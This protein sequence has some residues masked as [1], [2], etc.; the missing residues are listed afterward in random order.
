MQT[1][2]STRLARRMHHNKVQNPSYA[3]AIHRVRF[4]GLTVPVLKRLAVAAGLSIASKATK[5]E[6]VDALVVSKVRGPVSS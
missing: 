6:V 4:Q 5:A 3:P 1:K 2:N